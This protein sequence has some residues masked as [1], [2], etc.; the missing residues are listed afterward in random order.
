MLLGFAAFVDG[1][2]EQES[3]LGA[4]AIRMVQLLGLKDQLGVT[5]VEREVANACRCATRFCILLPD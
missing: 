2:I 1:A 4:Q 3:L 5:R